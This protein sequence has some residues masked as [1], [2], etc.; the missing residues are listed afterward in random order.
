MIKNTSGISGMPIFRPRILK[1]SYILLFLA[2]NRYKRLSS[3]GIGFTSLI[4]MI[5]IR[6]LCY[7]VTLRQVANQPKFRQD[8]CAVRTKR[9]VWVWGHMSGIRGTDSGLSHS[10]IRGLVTDRLMTTP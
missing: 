7:E 5:L 9:V 8:F 1:F 3:S 6:N 2:V 4:D 10:V